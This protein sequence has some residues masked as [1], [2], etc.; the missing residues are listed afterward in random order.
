MGYEIDSD[1]FLER[2]DQWVYGQREKAD[3]SKELQLVEE[4]HFGFFGNCSLED[5]F[6]DIAY[7]S[8]FVDFLDDIAKK[9]SD[10]LYL[11]DSDYHKHE[12]VWNLLTVI[13]KMPSE[14]YDDYETDAAAC[15][16][17]HNID[18]LEQ[19]DF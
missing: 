10:D 3:I 17:D 16:T 14:I 5:M 19:I 8:R 18:Y 12:R 7:D 2:L 4:Y 11:P 13:G 15:K 6:E 9:R 1:C